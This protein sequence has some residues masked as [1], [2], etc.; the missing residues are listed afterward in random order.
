MIDLN[1]IMRYIGHISNLIID[2]IIIFE[3]SPLRRFLPG[4]SSSAAQQPTSAISR[5]TSRF[6]DF[7]PDCKFQFYFKFD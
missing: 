5:S 6:R 3:L 4:N 2:M 7:R 1:A